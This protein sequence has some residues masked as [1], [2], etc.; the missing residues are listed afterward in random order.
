MALA[1]EYT[2]Q[3]NQFTVVSK[4]SCHFY[5]HYLLIYVISKKKHLR[6]IHTKH[7]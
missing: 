5:F 2:Q 7:Q 6:T 4:D 3:T 1:N